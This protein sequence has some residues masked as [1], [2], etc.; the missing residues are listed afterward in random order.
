MELWG[1]R[2][3]TSDLKGERKSVDLGIQLKRGNRDNSM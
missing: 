1:G 2:T 3:N